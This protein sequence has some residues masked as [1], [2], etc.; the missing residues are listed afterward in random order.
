MTKNEISAIYDPDFETLLNQW[1]LLAKL[2]QGGLKCS[3]CKTIL[4]Q[5]TI[6]AIYSDSG[7][8]KFVCD[9][10]DCIKA[11]LAKKEAKYRV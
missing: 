6:S 9:E 11:F 7:S 1:G 2:Q 10:P 3:I 8:I 5:E 4:T